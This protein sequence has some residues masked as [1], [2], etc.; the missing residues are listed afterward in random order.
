MIQ[1]AV[2]FISSWK[3][4]KELLKVQVSRYCDKYNLEFTNWKSSLNILFSKDT[5][6]EIVFSGEK[7]TNWLCNTKWSV[8]KIYG[9]ETVYRLG[10]TQAFRYVCIYYI[11]INETIVNEKFVHEF[12]I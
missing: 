3:V 7:H 6:V 1:M 9:Q 5:E 12:E 4:L 11:Y 8:L 2:V 10:C